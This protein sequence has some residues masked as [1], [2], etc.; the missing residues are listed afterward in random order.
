[1]TKTIQLSV[2]LGLA[3]VAACG[4]KGDDKSGGAAKGSD[5]PAPA[6]VWKKVASIGIEVALNRWAMA[7]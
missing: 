7:G 5:K 3:L 1:M 6:P 4:K 2:V